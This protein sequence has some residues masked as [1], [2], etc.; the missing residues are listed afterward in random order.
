[1]QITKDSFPAIMKLPNLEMLTLAGC[2][3][4]DDEAL[5]SIEKDCSKS[6]QV[7]IVLDHFDP[8]CYQCLIIISH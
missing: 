5:G 7:T 6:L 1:L 2:S 3:G 4:I 8:T